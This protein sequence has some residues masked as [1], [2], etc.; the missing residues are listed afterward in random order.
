MATIAV[1]APV[2]VVPDGLAVRGDAGL[3]LPEPSFAYRAVLDHVC[4]HHR[5]RR[6]LLAPANDFGCGVPEQEAARRYLADRQVQRLEA[7]ASPPGSYI[8]TRGNAA[9]LR[10]YLQRIGNWPIPPAILAVTQPQTGHFPGI[11]LA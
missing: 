3:T 6:I 1:P 8:D 5:D 4:A 11:H 2:I 7:P 10:G 9:T